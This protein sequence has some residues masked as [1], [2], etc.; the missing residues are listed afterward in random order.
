LERIEAA[1]RGETLFVVASD[2][3]PERLL[4]RLADARRSGATLLSLDAGDRE[5]GALAHDRIVV[6]GGPTSSSADD[7]GLIV[8]TPEVPTVDMDVVQHLVS[9]SAGESGGARSFRTRLARLLERLSGPVP[10]R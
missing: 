5:L 9:L 6:P 1:G 8:P 7:A 10:E 3:T 2:D 4:E